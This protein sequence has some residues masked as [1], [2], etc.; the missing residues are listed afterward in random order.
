MH[1]GRRGLRCGRRRTHNNH[2]NTHTHKY[3]RA[4]RQGPR[5]PP[6]ASIR[7]SG[8][9][10]GVGRVERVEPPEQVV[11]VL[12]DHVGQLLRPYGGVERVGP[13]PAAAPRA[14]GVSLWRNC[15]R[16]AR[17]GKVSLGYMV[18]PMYASGRPVAEPLRTIRRDWG[19]LM[20]GERIASQSEVIRAIV[21]GHNL[22]HRPK[23]SSKV[24]CLR[25]S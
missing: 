9:S 3:R 12:R 19:H 21:A 14:K 7:G 24:G 4:H 13:R 2:C 10:G 11:V 22:S 1:Q 6:T 5:K 16:S 23:A 15:S 17:K 18:A 8:A 20:L 25:I